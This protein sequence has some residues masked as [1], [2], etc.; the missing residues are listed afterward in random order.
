VSL[1]NARHA[2][3]IG[4]LTIGLEAFAA[5]TEL[6]TKRFDA[7]GA[8]LQLLCRVMSTM[9]SG[10]YIEAQY[11][12]GGL[13][14]DVATLLREVDVLVLPTTVSAAPKIGQ[15]EMREGMS[16]TVALA[17]AC[18]FAFLGNLTGLPSGTAPVGRGS[19]GMPFGLQVIADA[20]DEAT[21][22]QVLGHLERRG[23][24]EVSRPRLDAM[25]LG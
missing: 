21:V 5:L 4:Y 18:R 16:D 14:R 8:D 9:G 13:R 6:R 22:L 2:P 15:V 7:L 10:D 25:L 12:R 19:S 17:G 24:A 20:W 23:L 11:L 1:A 3:A